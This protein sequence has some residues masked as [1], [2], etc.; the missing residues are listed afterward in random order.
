[1]IISIDKH[2]LSKPLEQAA[3]FISSK[4]V[5]PIMAEIHFKADSEGLF[6]TGGNGFQFLRTKIDSDDFQLIKP[7]AITISGKRI[8]EVVKVMKGVIDIDSSGLETTVKNDRKKYQLPG[9]DPNEYPEINDD[10]GETTLILDGRSLKGIVKDTAYAAYEK[11]DKPILMGLLLKVKNNLINITSTDRHRLSSSVREAETL[12][13][14]QIVVGAKTMSEL[15][16]LIVPEEKIEIK[17]Q[18]SK[19]IV[20]TKDF[21]FFSRVLDGAFP[22]TE[23]ITPTNFETT[24]IVDREELIEALGGLKVIFKDEKAKLIKMFVGESIELKA[25]AEG[26]GKADELID[27]ISIQGN[28]FRIAYNGEYA[29]EAAESIHSKQLIIGYSGPTSPMK[30]SDADDERNFCIILPY[31]IAGV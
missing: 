7:G 9:M 15:M 20:K 5:L 21:I 18:D 16:N 31:R 30:F 2:I 3:K 6:I 29:L 28:S 27:I 25:E 24:I 14:M 1:M 10:T 8:S 13:D 23:R 26:V 17:F 22:D 11:E 12:E 4:S 19:F